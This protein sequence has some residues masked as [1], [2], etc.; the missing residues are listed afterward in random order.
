MVKCCLL[1]TSLSTTAFRPEKLLFSS[2]MM[3]AKFV[4]RT[5]TSCSIRAVSYTHLQCWRSGR[6]HWLSRRAS[7]GIRRMYF[8]SGYYW[9]F[10][11]WAAASGACFF[12]ISK[13][14]AHFWNRQSSKSKAVWMATRMYDWTATGRENFTVCFTPLM[15]WRQF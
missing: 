11:C 14:R 12:A 6:W 3:R 5:D 7:Y 15:H 4:V 9:F 10:C 2:F 1:Y 13:G 8:L